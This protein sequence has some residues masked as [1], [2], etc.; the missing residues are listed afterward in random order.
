MLF[1]LEVMVTVVV[2]SVVV[3]VVVVIVAMA[4]E[5]NF[6]FQFVS[7]PFCSDALLWW[8]PHPNVRS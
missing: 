7:S 1:G 5:R 4:T 8:I 3:F 2:V 6:A